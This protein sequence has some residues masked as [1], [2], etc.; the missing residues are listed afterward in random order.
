MAG[1]GAFGS[2][3]GFVAA[4]AGSA[5]GLGNI[6]R[7]PYEAGRNGGAAFLL[8]YIICIIIIG[9]PIMAGEISMG[10]SSRANPY[11]AYTT[12]GNR[13][14]RW[15]GLWGIICGIM[16][17][18]VYNVVAGWAFG[19]FI[20]ITF[21]DLMTIQ[22]YGG[23]FTDYTSS[24]G[25]NFFYSLAFMLI[26]AMIVSRGIQGGIEKA[27]KI[28]M[29]ILLALLLGLIIYSL[30]LPNAMEGVKYYLIPD[31]GK[32]NV[33][34]V[35]S[36]LGQAFFSLSL[37]MGALIT[38]GSYINKND[39]IAGSAGLVTG[40]DT[41][42]A[43]LA[44][45]MIFPLVFSMGQSPEAGPGLVF[46]ALPGIFQQMGPVVGKIIGSGFFLL[47]C[48]AAL[49]STISL[50]EIPTSF[51]VDEKKWPRKL[52]AWVGAIV[53]FLIGLPSMLSQGAVEGL[54][55]FLHYEGQAKSFFDVVFDVFSD[56]G[57]P[58]G[59]LLMVIF[60]T[61]K[62]GIDKFDEE[63]ASGNENYMTSLVRK[64]LHFSI[65]WVT[66]ILLAT[67]F[68]ITIL[69]KFLGIQVFG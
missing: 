58:L 4:A 20:Q 14:W 65:R 41:I 15:V 36:A 26:T 23:F 34:T 61:R 1:R 28:L 44:G 54:S 38:Y 62:W 66:P 3:L 24:I 37:G 9:Y 53:V 55:N 30:T 40:A 6:W 42:I 59:G 47:L 43:F 11:R 31:F 35:Y 56:T 12:L 50:L 13:N 7:F 22:D 69:Q 19:Y 68:V 10:R 51:L 32:I 2:R 8:V 18:S 33:R 39:N 16:F 67:I 49:T 45:L 21:M 17:L 52:V 64:F 57:L 29:P 63:N 25:A 5:V 27:S 48:F 46:V 60:I